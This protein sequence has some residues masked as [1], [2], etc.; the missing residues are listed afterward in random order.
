MAISTPEV[1]DGW[2]FEHDPFRHVD[3]ATAMS[4]LESDLH[5]RLGE[6]ARKEQSGVTGAIRVQ[7]QR[8]LPKFFGAEISPA[9]ISHLFRYI[10]YI[11][12]QA[13]R[14]MHPEWQ[15]DEWDWSTFHSTASTVRDWKDK[16]LRAYLGE[17]EARTRKIGSFAHVLAETDAKAEKVLDGGA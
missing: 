2:G 14:A 12:A 15:Q 11:S 9:T 7:L 13:A 3:Y 8:L 17:V 1:S 5:E 4:V 10:E 6:V 16:E